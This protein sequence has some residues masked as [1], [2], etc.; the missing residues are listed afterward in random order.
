MEVA[1]EVESRHFCLRALDGGRVPVNLLYLL[2]AFH[3]SRYNYENFWRCELNVLKKC[4][5]S[6]TVDFTDKRNFFKMMK[7]LDPRVVVDSLRLMQ[8]GA[9]RVLRYEVGGVE[10]SVTQ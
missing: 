6:K 5:I 9:V 10:I 4:S 7:D 1:E 3:D 2:C 8:K